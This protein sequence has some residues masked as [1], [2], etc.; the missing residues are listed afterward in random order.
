MPPE[1]QLCQRVVLTIP[2]G[3]RHT[4]ELPAF[5]HAAGRP[6]YFRKGRV[7]MPDT[8][9]GALLSVECRHGRAF[10]PCNEDGYPL[11][12]AVTPGEETSEPIPARGVLRL[13]PAAGVQ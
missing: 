2:A 5:L 9:T 4:E 13:A 7:K 11:Q 3:E 6:R 8:M 1:P 10:V 12:I